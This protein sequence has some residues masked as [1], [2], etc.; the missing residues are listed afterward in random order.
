MPAGNTIGFTAD[1]SG[2]STSPNVL[3]SGVNASSEYVRFLGT[4]GLSSSFSDLIAAL[5]SN[6]FR[7]GLHVQGIGELGGSE[8]FVDGL[9]SPSQVPV[10][11]AVWL[12]GSAILGFAGF[13]KRKS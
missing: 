5:D 13:N 1:A 7:I 3:A 8:S 4:F 11:G 9:E 6:A 12:F 2:D 10:P